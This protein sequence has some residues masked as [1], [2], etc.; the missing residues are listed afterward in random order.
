MEKITKEQ[1]NTL[2]K[3]ESE[4]GYQSLLR[5]SNEDMRI[6]KEQ[7]KNLDKKVK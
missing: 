6:M 5:Q 3:M 2:L 7:K 1:D 4:T